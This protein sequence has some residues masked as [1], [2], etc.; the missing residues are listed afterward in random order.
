V[1][2]SFDG[3]KMTATNRQTS[4]IRQNEHN[5]E[6]A[7]AKKADQSRLLPLARSAATCNARSIRMRRENAVY[8]EI[9]CV[10]V[11]AC[12]RVS[13]SSSS[14]KIR[15][16]GIVW[17]VG[18]VVES[19]FT[20]S[21]SSYKLCNTICG[22]VAIKIISLRARRLVSAT[23]NERKKRNEIPEFLDLHA[24]ATATNTTL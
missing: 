12:V 9:D 10:H 15:Q 20:S 5:V 14:V 18:D 4:T 11:R 17:L 3:F 16:T 6:R 23:R 8:D 21:Q 7:Y 13:S 24:C 2:V 1:T 19:G 22:S